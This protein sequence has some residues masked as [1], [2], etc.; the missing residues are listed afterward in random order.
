LRLSAFAVNLLN[1]LQMKTFFNL[2]VTLA[3]VCFN[4]YISFATESNNYKPS[5]PDTLG[6]ILLNQLGY[7]P[8]A[9][10][11][12]LLRVKTDKFEVV[13]TSTGKVVF[14]GKPGN[15]NYWKFSGDT[16]CAAD[17]S[18]L[19]TPGKYQL[20]IENRT[21]CSYPFEIG[22]NVYNEVAKA[23]IK[24]FYLNRSGIDIPKEYGGKWAR[25]AGHPDTA[26]YVHSSAASDKR[27]E[28]YKISSPGGWYDAGDYNKY[29]VNSGITTYTL[30]L[31]C[32]MYPEYIK[33]FS[34]N[35]PESKNDIPDVMDELL[36]NLRW[37]LTMQD[38]ND[39][40]VYHKL[41]NKNFDG[42]VM[43]DKAVEPRYVVL[44]STTAA[45]DFAATMAMASRVFANSNSHEL[46]NLGKT[47]LDAAHR[48][49]K[50]AKANPAIY[51][52][53]PSDIHTGQYDDV[54][55][56]DE[57]F[58]AAVEM[59]LTTND[60]A[61]IN[62]DDIYNQM[63]IVPSWDTLGMLGMISLSLTDNSQFS[64]YKA[65]AQ[66][67]LLNYADE[68]V[69][70]SE[71]SPYKVSI[72]FFKWGSNS[73]VAN[74]ALL[75][76]IAYRISNDKKYLPSIQADVDY[77]LGRNATGYSFVTGYGGKQVMHLHHRPSEADGVKE[78][79]PGFLAG[80]PNIVTF[81]DCPLIERSKFP[82]KSYVDA[83]CSYST[84]ENAINWNA[85]LFFVMAAMD[86]MKK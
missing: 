57:F 18:K 64:D 1:Y 41:T 14:T 28:G 54:K 74:M 39:G 78:P 43:P 5:E 30:L 73:D 17:F 16:V 45:L 15:M 36:Y 22:E 34:F 66:K 62:K 35:I 46:K 70:K 84:N 85:P 63:V 24:A 10:K 6:R 38:P 2:L 37:M 69:K 9:S 72:D 49:Y 83:L 44:K 23:S 51:Y 67:I 29:I 48:A 58:W 59:G 21:I 71:T 55:I 50:W 65:V 68:L 86:A 61:Y 7:Q 82:A 56:K 20:C 76:I 42:F 77:I 8:A 19:T 79:Y 12:A 3:T 4:Y 75:K 47:C 40:G 26:V 32:Q 31:F 60:K 11:I 33:A 53:N 13:E 80:G 52:K 27:P 81:G 25:T